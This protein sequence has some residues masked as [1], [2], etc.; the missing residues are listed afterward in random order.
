L[1]S[2]HPHLVTLAD[3]VIA[4]TTPDTLAGHDV[5]FMA[6]PHGQSGPIAAELGDETL[7]IDLGADHRLTDPVA[8]E[9][10]YGT[11]FAGTWPYG[12]PELPTRAG[13]Q[14][15]HLAGV[16][17]VAVAGC[18]VAAVTLASAPGVAAGLVDS[19]DLVAVLAV[20]TSGAGRS[21]AGHLLAS[22][23][24]GSATPYAVGGS[25]R[26][27]P[28]IE[29][30]LSLAGAAE[31]RMS[32]TPVLVPMSRG[33][34]ATVTAPLATA[35]DPGAVR[36]AWLDAYS[37]G[38][39]VHLL[40]TGQWPATGSTIGSNAAH[41][42]VALDQRARRVVAVCALDNLGKGAAGAAVQCLNLAMGLPESTGLTATGVAP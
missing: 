10:F 27:I 31:V 40:P 1:G 6:L 28:E 9:Q 34:L 20:G 24:L 4:P 18:N 23:R 22:E 2:H 5:V 12:L 21:T 11:P 42:Q 13:I 36:A 33:I 17:R 32:F 3:R 30:N 14:R 35:A 41:V 25:H 26:H 16:N 38:P 39:F 19:S 29:Q 15:A 8:W 37:D 7:V